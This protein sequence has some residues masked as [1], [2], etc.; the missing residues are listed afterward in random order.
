MMYHY[1]CVV[2]IKRRRIPNIKNPVFLCK[3]FFLCN[4]LSW[5]NCNGTKMHFLIVCV[6][7]LRFLTK[8]NHTKMRWV[9]VS[10]NHRNVF[11][12]MVS[13]FLGRKSKTVQNAIRFFGRYQ[14]LVHPGN[15]YP[16]TR[17]LSSN[18]IYTEYVPNF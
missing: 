6:L 13:D 11:S 4:L 5:L 1:K 16:S 8:V 12:F 3:L 9:W 10:Q 15:G 14:T 17:K 2:Q 18:Q 7:P